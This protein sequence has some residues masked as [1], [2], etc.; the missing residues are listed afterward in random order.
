ML[1]KTIKLEMNILLLK[2]TKCLD[3]RPPDEDFVAT[4]FA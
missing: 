1:I 4:D 3:L 2:M